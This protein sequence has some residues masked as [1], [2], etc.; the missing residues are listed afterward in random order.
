[1]CVVETENGNGGGAEA[2]RAVVSSCG[3]PATSGGGL[4]SAVMIEVR[5]RI[6]W[7]WGRRPPPLIIKAFE[8]GGRPT[9]GNEMVGRRGGGGVTS[10]QE[11]V[12][13]W[14]GPEGQRPGRA[15]RRMGGGGQ[16]SCARKRTRSHVPLC[17]M[18]HVIG[19]PLLSQKYRLIPTP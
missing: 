4:S 13:W 7:E 11:V 8:G 12:G 2:V 5:G 19:G 16:V 9:A 10:P 3:C 6:V 17:V 18:G 14:A 1:V 15:R